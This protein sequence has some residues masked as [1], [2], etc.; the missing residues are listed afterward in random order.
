MLSSGGGGNLFIGP[1]IPSGLPFY[2]KIASKGMYFVA[3]SGDG[4]CSV[5]QI[6]QSALMFKF[7]WCMAWI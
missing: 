6:I 5:Q 4:H 1:S 3:A 2:E 7:A